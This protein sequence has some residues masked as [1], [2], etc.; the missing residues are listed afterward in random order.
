FAA[1]AMVNEVVWSG[2]SRFF[3]QL[4]PS[5]SI[6]AFS[7]FSAA[8]SG[9]ERA[10]LASLI[11]QSQDDFSRSRGFD[12]RLYLMPSVGCLPTSLDSA[13]SKLIRRGGTWLSA[14]FSSWESADT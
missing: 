9:A 12:Q 6:S 1:Q 4:I 7:S 13:F 10:P 3:G 8:R 2:D 14:D 11:Q 5:S